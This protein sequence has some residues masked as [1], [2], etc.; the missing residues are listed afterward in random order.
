MCPEFALHFACPCLNCVCWLP[1]PSA[2]LC[3]CTVL[4]GRHQAVQ[5]HD[6]SDEEDGGKLSALQH[7]TKQQQ[8]AGGSSRGQQQQQQLPPGRKVFDRTQLLAVPVENLSKWQRKRMRQK[9]KAAAA[10]QQQ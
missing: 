1:V 2:I 8:H 6:S 5:Q 10:G 3:F 7:N 9:E 4:Q